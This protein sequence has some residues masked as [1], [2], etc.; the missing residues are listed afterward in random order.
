ML[1]RRPAID[2]GIGFPTDSYRA[3]GG[4]NRLHQI[5][6]TNEKSDRP[7]DFI[8][9]PVDM[10]IFSQLRSLYDS[11]SDA[12]KQGLYAFT[13]SYDDADED[14]VYQML[15][16]YIELINGFREVI[17]RSYYYHVV[18]HPSYIAK[19]SDIGKNLQI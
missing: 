16:L 13:P 19:E 18:Y 14:T 3:G 15:D 10:S 9:I 7:E 1:V 11:L 5:V 4:G 2:V 6:G 8:A 12:S 17:P